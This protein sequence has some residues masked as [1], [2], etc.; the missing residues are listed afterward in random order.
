MTEFQV[1]RCGTRVV[2]KDHTI[3]TQYPGESTPR[4]IYSVDD[5]WLQPLRHCRVCGNPVSEETFARAYWELQAQA[6]SPECLSAETLKRYACCQ[7]AQPLPCVCFY[8]TTCPDHGERHFGTH[9]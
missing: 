8:A 5:E 6:C 4:Y 1:H 9:D 3:G 2:L 7:K